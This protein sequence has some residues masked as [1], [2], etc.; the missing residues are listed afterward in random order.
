MLVLFFSFAAARRLNIVPCL[1][2]HNLG[3]ACP[4]NSKF[5]YD[6]F[7]QF[8]SY[9]C[10]F[11]GR[12]LSDC[13]SSVHEAWAGLSRSFFMTAK[14]KYDRVFL[15]VHYSL[16]PL[17][18]C[19]AECVDVRYFLQMNSL[20]PSVRLRRRRPEPSSRRYVTS[21]AFLVGAR[22]SRSSRILLSR[23]LCASLLPRMAG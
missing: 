2:L 20:S 6:S 16:A 19:R 7:D 14:Y 21:I 17:Q 9:A 23:S 18:W 13:M 1:P 4:V 15:D 3:E 22:C 11:E 12:R 5:T 10:T 8:S